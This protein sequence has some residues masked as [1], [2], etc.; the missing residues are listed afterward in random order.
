MREVENKEIKSP[1]GSDKGDGKERTERTRGRLAERLRI[2]EIIFSQSQGHVYCT[3]AILNAFRSL[4]LLVSGVETF[5]LFYLYSLFLFRRLLL[6]HPRYVHSD[7]CFISSA[8]RNINI[9]ICSCNLF[10]FTSRVM[11]QPA[12]F[13]GCFFTATTVTSMSCFLPASK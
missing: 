12:V 2:Q 9:Y 3:L 1:Q 10:T 5:C 4:I 6:F 13:L 8:S 7:T 11:N